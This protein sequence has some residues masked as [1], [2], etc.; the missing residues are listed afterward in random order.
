MTLSGKYFIIVLSFIQCISSCKNDQSANNVVKMN[1]AKIQTLYMSDYF[2]SI[3][4][5][6]LE[7]KNECLI[8]N[9]PIFY[10]LDDFIVVADKG[11]CF[12]FDRLTGKFIRKIG[13]HGKGAGEY[14]Q[15][16][17]GIIINEQEKTIFFVQGDHLIEYSLL[18]GAAVNTPSIR[19]SPISLNKIAYII[20][21]DIWAISCLNIYGKHPNQMLFFDR[22]GMIDS[23]P[24]YHVFTPKTN[25]VW[26]YPEEIFF[27]SYNK[28]VYH[29]YLYSDTIFKIVDRKMQPEWIFQMK[30]SPHILNQVRDTPSILSKEMVNYHLIYPILETDEYIFFNTKY[31]KQIHTFLFDKKRC[32]VKA[33]EHGGF[34]ND[35]D[36]G[37][38]FW[39]IVTNQNQD[40]ACIYQAD[41]MKDEINNNNLR[42]QNVKNIPAFKK[43][44]ALISQ[45][46]EED[47]PIVIIAKLK[48]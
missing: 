9:N 13:T 3:E 29:K 1:D 24:N 31:Q 14:L 47:N 8:G 25:E 18:D 33:L 37:L 35:I 4:Y 22:K 45:L 48:K 2:E 19:I 34:I 7:T 38:T 23:I 20:K 21:E 17:H 42:E 26:I 43:L 6:P 39:P 28:N 41:V 46:D 36:G 32:E 40:L 30:R 5:I 16:P 12:A 27:Y 11:N 10:L 44:Q 15:I